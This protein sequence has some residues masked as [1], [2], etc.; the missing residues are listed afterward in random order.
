MKIEIRSSESA[1]IEGYVNVVERESRMIPDRQGNFIEIVKQGAFADAIKR[2]E[3][4][5]V[6][7]NHRKI[8]GDTKVKRLKYMKIKSV[9][10]RKHMSAILQ[11]SKQLLKMSCEAGLL[12]LLLKV[13]NGKILMMV[14][15]VD[16]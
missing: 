12:V 8:L 3:N 7:F 16:I 15:G 2:A 1:V 6:R 5:E 13:R 10:M 14:S 9:F 4:V 11:S